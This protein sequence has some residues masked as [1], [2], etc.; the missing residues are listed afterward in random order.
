MSGQSASTLHLTVVWVSAAIGQAWEFQVKSLEFRSVLPPCRCGIG[1][2]SVSS[3]I[4]LCPG[5]FLVHSPT[6]DLVLGS[7]AS[8]NFYFFPLLWLCSPPVPVLSEV[9]MPMK[10]NGI[11]L[12][13]RFLFS[14]SGMGAWNRACDYEML[15]SEPHSEK[16]NPRALLPLI[17]T[18]TNFHLANS[19]SVS[20]TQ[21]QHHISPGDY[22][23]TFSYSSVQMPHMVVTFIVILILLY[24]PYTYWLYFY[25]PHLTCVPKPLCD[26]IHPQCPAEGLECN[27]HH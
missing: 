14:R 11:M 10:N 8:P 27:R 5:W 15:V 19:Y 7:W 22:S 21:L 16:Q 1:V 2:G 4:C 17:H 18:D 24:G 6:P 25:L 3:S 13:I 23:D 9:K 26:F 20:E 12:K